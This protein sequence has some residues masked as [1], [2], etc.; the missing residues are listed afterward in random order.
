MT[1]VTPPWL[2][3][4]ASAVTLISTRSPGASWT[5]THARHGH[6]SAGI[7][8]FHTESISAFLPMSVRSAAHAA[9]SEAEK[10]G[11]MGVPHRWSRRQCRAS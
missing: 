10:K 9:Q 4:L 11:W 5:P 1:H 2:P 6:A 8:A 7:H 3:H